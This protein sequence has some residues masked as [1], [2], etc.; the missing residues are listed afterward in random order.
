V[1]VVAVVAT[2][3]ATASAFRPSEFSALT[4]SLTPAYDR[5]RPTS[6]PASMT[7]ALVVVHHRA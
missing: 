4:G 1:R 3:S 7:Y 6:A 2:R 5:F